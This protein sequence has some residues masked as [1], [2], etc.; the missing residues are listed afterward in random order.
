MEQV[1]SPAFSSPFP[2]GTVF[3]DG[4]DSSVVVVPGPGDSESSKS[5]I[6]MLSGTL[7]HTDVEAINS[8]KFIE[9]EKSLRDSYD[10]DFLPYERV[11]EEFFEGYRSL[12][13]KIVEEV[14]DVLGDKSSSY[15]QRF[16]GRFMF[17]YFLQKKG[18]LGGAK[19]INKST[20]WYQKKML[21]EGKVIKVY[22]KV[23]VK[24]E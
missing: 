23:R 8:L 11:R 22:D 16:L 17:L 13:N 14:K 7:Y 20:L 19:K 9:D 2:V 6:L 10:S 21:K 15:S 3:T 5:R 18:W 1:S 4:K 12:Y 24:M